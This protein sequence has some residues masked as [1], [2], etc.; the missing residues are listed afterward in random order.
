MAN[1]KGC[2]ND[3]CVEN[4]K[5]TKFKEDALYCSK[6]GERLVY[7]CP[8]CFKELSDRNEKICS[9]C[10]RKKDDNK[11]KRKE[12]IKAAR[13]VALAAA[14]MVDPEVVKKVVNK[15]NATKV[16]NVV[17]KVVKK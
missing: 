15:D 13:G 9:D 2:L 3:N 7:V 17:K 4:A 11:E 12:K 16:V 8:S 1:V 6:C 10:Q 5:K 14:K